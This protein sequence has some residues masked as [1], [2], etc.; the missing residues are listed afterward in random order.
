MVERRGAPTLGR[1][2]THA[3]VTEPCP[4]MAWILRFPEQLIMTLFTAAEH[5]FEISSNV[6]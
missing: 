1:V 2:A 5:K 3:I 4:L 6:A